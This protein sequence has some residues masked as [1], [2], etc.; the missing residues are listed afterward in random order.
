MQSSNPFAYATQVPAPLITWILLLTLVPAPSDAT[1]PS[2]PVRFECPAGLSNLSTTSNS[3]TALL[4]LDCPRIPLQSST[5]ADAAPIKLP[6]LRAALCGL[7]GCA[8]MQSSNPFAYATQVPA[9]LITWILLLTLVPAPSDATAP[10]EPVRFECPAGL[11]NLSTTSNSQTAPPLL[12]L[13]CPRI[14]L[15]SSTTADAAPIKLPHLRAAICG[16]GGCATMQSSNPFAY[17]TQVSKLYC[18]F[19][20]KSSDYCLLQLPGPQCCLSVA[21]ECADVVRALLL[22]AGDVETNPGPDAVLDE[23]KKL[24]AGQSQL[25]TEVQ[26]LKNQLKTTE[27]AI[28]ALSN[29]L[30]DL[31][32]HY[33]DLV[34]LRTDIDSICANATQTA[35]DIREIEARLDDAENRSRRNNLIF[36]NIADNNKSETYAESEE[37]VLRLCRDHLNITIDPKEIER[38]HRLGRHSAGRVR[39]IIVKFTFFKTKEFILSNGRKLKGTDYGIGEDFSRPVRIARKHLITFVKTKATKFSLRYKTLSIGPKRYVFDEPSQTIKEIA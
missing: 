27:Q 29:R 3:Q 33:Q 11:S 24:S 32:T 35:K 7:G 16:L 2:E 5:T 37:T 38:A 17:A 1:A 28:S 20:K 12:F 10:S 39:P 9:P 21:I 31:E 36:Y 22:L 23:L 30:S 4:F 25:L 26:G 15:R 8:T 14:P 6:H 19:T 18:L 34:A 13:D